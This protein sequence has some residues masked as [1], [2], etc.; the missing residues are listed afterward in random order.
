VTIH[1]FGEARELLHLLARHATGQ[2][3]SCAAAGRN[4]LIPKPRQA[5]EDVQRKELINHAPVNARRTA[6][7]TRCLGCV[8]G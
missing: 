4:Q 5:L 7:C 1:Q 2:Y 6:G 8:Y 3:C